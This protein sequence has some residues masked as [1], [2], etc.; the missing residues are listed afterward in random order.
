MDARPV[1]RWHQAFAQPATYLGIIAIIIVL[2]GA[3]FLEK[4]EY[5]RAERDG[6]QR[7]T[8]FARA[9]EQ[10]VASL[11]HSIDSQ[12][13][14]LSQIFRKNQ[15]DLDLLFR[16]DNSRLHNNLEVEFI[17]VGPDGFIK[18]TTSSSHPEAMFVGD[19]G[20]FRDQINS[21]RDH[22]FI[23]APATD[24]VSMDA[25]I[26]LSRRLTASDGT[27]GGVIVASIDM[28]GFKQFINS[29]DIGQGGLISLIGFDGTLR[30]TDGNA[31]NGSPGNLVGSP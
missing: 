23:G 12:L 5:E 17:L 15:D 7:T 9:F 27:F 26:Q 13:L 16:F 21:S 4:E 10:H 30:A 22:L 2:V 6:I 19:R 1:I 20:Y 28:L 14:F 8:V 11:F 29:I 18:V 25:T 24:H 31:S 3:F